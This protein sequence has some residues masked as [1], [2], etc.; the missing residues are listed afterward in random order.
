MSVIDFYVCIVWIESVFTARVF[1]LNFGSIIT[2]WLL[3][4]KCF[5]K[6][7]VDFSYGYKK[8]S[9]KHYEL[10]NLTAMIIEVLK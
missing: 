5:F 7:D 4:I 2:S 9:I 1:I 10:V 8:I 3:K 6:F